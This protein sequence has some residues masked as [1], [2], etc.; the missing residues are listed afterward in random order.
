MRKNGCTLRRAF[1]SGTRENGSRL[2]A[3]FSADHDGSR[4]LF[5]QLKT[6]IFMAVN[7]YDELPGGGWGRE[8][9]E[10]EAAGFGNAVDG[11]DALPRYIDPLSDWG[12]KRLFGTEMN[13]EFLVDFLDTI[14]PDKRIRDITYLP[15]ESLGLAAGD[16]NARFDVMCVDDKGDRFIV[17]IQLAYQKFFRERALYYSGMALHSQGV[18]GKRWDYGISGVYFVGLMNFNFGGKNGGGLIRR[19]SIREDETGALM[20]DKLRFVFIEIGRFDKSPEELRTNQ[21]KWLFVLRNLNR[22]L[23]RPAALIDR[24]F[25]RF[26]EA[27]E[28]ISLTKDEKK[29]YVNNMINERDTYN[30]IAYAREVGME[31]GMEKG[32][33]KGMEKGMAQGRNDIAVKMVESGLPIDVIVRCTGLDKGAVEALRKKDEDNK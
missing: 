27:A 23:E 16:R 8:L 22:L 21:D 11:E 9:L 15:T 17:E 2:A 7:G 5:N 4:D 32:L 13:K 25:L 6:T 24:I 29:Q 3:G 28:V 30:Q 14:F 1:A 26:F 10:D 31:E 19:Y 33:K 12:F 20:T 18:K